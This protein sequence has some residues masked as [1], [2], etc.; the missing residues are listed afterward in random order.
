MVVN[1]YV[2]RLMSFLNIVVS[3]QMNKSFKW[4]HIVILIVD[5]KKIRG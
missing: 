3:F 5:K 2:Q 1:M 4:F